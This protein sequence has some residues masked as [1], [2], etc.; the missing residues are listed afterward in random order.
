MSR[1]ALC[2]TWVAEYLMN[3]HFNLPD[4]DT[5]DQRLKQGRVAHAGCVSVQPA[6][7]CAGCAEGKSLPPRRVALAFRCA[8]VSACATGVWRESP[9]PP[10]SYVSKWAC[11]WLCVCPARGL[12]SL[13]VRGGEVPLPRGDVWTWCVGRPLLHVGMLCTTGV[14]RESPSPLLCCVVLGCAAGFVCAQPVVCNHGSCG[15]RPLL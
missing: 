13:W 1:A 2:A 14:R 10:L 4:P 12:P 8:C 15:P 11:C 5:E 9:S 6:L 7:A 3:T